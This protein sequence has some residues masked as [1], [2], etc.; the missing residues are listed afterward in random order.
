M[1]D[2]MAWKSHQLPPRKTGDIYCRRTIVLVILA[3]ASTGLLLQLVPLQAVDAQQVPPQ[4][5]LAAVAG[6][7][8]EGGVY[9]PSNRTLLRGI[10][11]ARQRI[12]QGEYT[13]AIRF[14]NDVLE[15]EEDSFEATSPI[16]D[17]TLKVQDESLQYTGLK[18]TARRIIRDLPAEGRVAYELAYRAHAQRLLLAAIQSG[19]IDELSRIGRQYFYTPAGYEATLLYAQNETDHGRHLAAALA[20]G[21]LLDTPR[22]VERLQPQLSIL[23]AQSWLTAGNRQ[24]TQETLIQLK[25]W[26]LKQPNHGNL[27]RPQTMIIAGQ[28]HPLFGPGTLFDGA[29]TDGAAED[30][31]SRNNTAGVIDRFRQLVGDPDI[32][33]RPLERDWLTLHGNEAR[34]GQTEGGLPHLHVRWK[35]RLLGHPKLAFLYDDLMAEIAKSNK[36]ATVAASP[37]AI[38]NTIVTRSANQLIAVDFRTGKLVWVGGTA[39]M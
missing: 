15:Q 4:P 8:E 3:V 37:L 38:G 7:I 35:V 27:Q 11:T 10:A 5:V 19:S 28:H 24:R 21:Q 34:N 29:F 30:D 36:P 18:E 1:T 2:R 12:T 23:A 20:Y 22:A 25:Q 33:Q 39:K 6:S 26:L 13:Q 16:T 14:L 17:R 9:L 32:N 31:H